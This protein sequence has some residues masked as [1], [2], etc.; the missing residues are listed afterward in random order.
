MPELNVL[1]NQPIPPQ[2]MM[3][4]QKGLE[5]QGFKPDMF[6]KDYA[7]SDSRGQTVKTNALIYA[8]PTYRTPDYTALTVFNK[9]KLQNP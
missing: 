2:A 9:E 6:E 4:L 1:A 7:F 5:Q 3:S 8:D